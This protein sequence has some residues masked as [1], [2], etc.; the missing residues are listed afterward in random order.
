MVHRQSPE[1]G[2]YRE[3]CTYLLRVS[4]VKIDESKGELY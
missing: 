4:G 3:V 1:H 2:A